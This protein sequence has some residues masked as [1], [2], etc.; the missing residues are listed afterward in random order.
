MLYVYMYICIYM[1]GRSNFGSSGFGSSPSISVLRTLFVNM[2]F[3]QRNHRRS[4]LQPKC[5]F[6][7]ITVACSCAPLHACSGGHIGGANERKLA[8]ADE[9]KRAQANERKLAQDIK[10]IRK[11][12]GIANVR[13]MHRRFLAYPGRF[14]PV[15]EDAILQVRI[16]ARSP[17]GISDATRQL[18]FLTSRA[19][20]LTS[21]H[22]G[23]TGDQ[24][25]LTCLQEVRH[26]GSDSVQAKAIQSQHFSTILVE[27]FQVRQSFPVALRLLAVQRTFGQYGIGTHVASGDL[28][29]LVWQYLGG[30]YM[31]AGESIVIP[32]LQT[33]VDSLFQIRV[34]AM[35]HMPF[36]VFGNIQFVHQKA[37]LFSQVHAATGVTF[38]FPEDGWDHINDWLD[39]YDSW[40]EFLFHWLVSDVLMYA[41]TDTALG[42]ACAQI[43][44]LSAEEVSVETLPICMSGLQKKQCLSQLAMTCPELSPMILVVDNS[45]DSGS[46]LHH[47]D[48]NIR[49][50]FACLCKA[51]PEFLAVIIV[52]GSGYTPWDKGEGASVV[53]GHRC[54]THALATSLRSPT[55][56]VSVD[57]GQTLHRLVH[58]ATMQR[59]LSSSV[60]SHPAFKPLSL[61][62]AF[63]AQPEALLG[64]SPSPE[65]P[66][67]EVLFQSELS[68]RYHMP[69]M[70][71]P[72][73][74][75]SSM[76]PQPRGNGQ[77]HSDIMQPRPDIAS[78]GRQAMTA[79]LSASMQQRQNPSSMER[80]AHQTTNAWLPTLPQL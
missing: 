19:R 41:S 46:Q 22:F 55:S 20:W 12:P 52:S 53:I 57:N 14:Y 65:T 72:N 76:G 39:S 25:I 35:R 8:Q 74:V 47:E 64:C 54:V 80:C 60:W 43:E 16:C 7:T 18:L 45:K 79:Q 26:Q 69:C 62:L 66:L 2:D 1:S 33:I 15:P 32:K 49:S 51:M 30:A 73:I 58:D 44:A 3:R 48:V 63:H 29:C 75:A 5:C 56:Q 23:L 37:P 38:H 67:I 77:H 36:R 61:W 10:L 4:S 68:N 27:L 34:Q 59:S 71:I 78:A 28:H 9:R 40:H 21:L 24:E 50:R 13:V 70:H 11:L 42:R 6:R 17:S 31:V